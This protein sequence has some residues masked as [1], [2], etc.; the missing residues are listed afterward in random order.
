MATRITKKQK[1]FADN[2][3]DT[4][5]ATKAVLRVYDTNDDNTAAAIGSQNLRKLNVIDYLNLNAKAVASNM[6]KLAMEAKSEMAQINAGK[7]VLDRSG[8]KPTDKHLIEGN[9][10]LEQLF[11]KTKDNEQ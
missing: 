4:G 9:F 3:L 8:Y 5:N 10:T 6:L 1:A 7:D 2:Y 11:K